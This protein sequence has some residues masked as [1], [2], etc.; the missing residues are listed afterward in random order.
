MS[1][2]DNWDRWSQILFKSVESSVYWCSTGQGQ[3]NCFFVGCF[4]EASGTYSAINRYHLLQ[5]LF[6][7]S[8]NDLVC[9]IFPG[10]TPQPC[11]FMADTSSSPAITVSIGIFGNCESLISS[12]QL[13]LLFAF[14]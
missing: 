5:G 13:F 3:L 2:L 8:M 7:H 10:L 6:S 12:V 1:V 9:F 14:L 4:L 11:S